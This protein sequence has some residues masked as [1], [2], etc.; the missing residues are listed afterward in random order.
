MWSHEHSTRNKNK[1]KVVVKNSWVGHLLSNWRA[2][3]LKRN[4][5]LP[6]GK[7]VK[8][9]EQ[10]PE[11]G[12]RLGDGKVGICSKILKAEHLSFYFLGEEGRRTRTIWRRGGGVEVLG[13]GGR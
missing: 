7:S 1:K 6:T 2:E 13:K 5:L 9:S 10:T 4:V 3:N 8:R 11:K 12:N